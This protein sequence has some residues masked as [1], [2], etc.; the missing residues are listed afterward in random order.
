[1]V[2]NENMRLISVCCQINGSRRPGVS[3]AVRSAYVDS[4]GANIN[5]DLSVC[6]YFEMSLLSWQ[7]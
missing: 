5:A 4:F 1:M 7:Q 6:G 2:R 3:G